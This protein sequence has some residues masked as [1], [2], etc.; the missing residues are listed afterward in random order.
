MSGVRRSFDLF[1][2]FRAEGSDPDAFYGMLAQDVVDTISRRCEV[3][4]AVFV[5]VGGGTGHVATAMHQAG[6]R[7]ASIDL[8]HEG[9]NI[10]ARLVAD[11]RRLPIGSARVDIG[12]CSNVL[13][14][15]ADPW[16]V[17]SELTRIVKPGGMM[18]V[19]FTNWYSPWGGHESSPWHYAGGRY[20]ARRYERRTGVAPKN[21]Y[22]TSLFPLHIGSVL[23]KL[24]RS[25]DIDVLDAFP[26]YYPGWTRRVVAVPGLREVFT[27]NLALVLRRAR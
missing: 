22:G 17:L 5:D 9:Q 14:H 15:V 1:E 23:R 16:S 26:R 18:F 7:S 4:G 8:Q 21:L 12:H 11:G 6:A 25:D 24:R 27:W 3:A 20:A 10:G 2:A 13:E 19:S